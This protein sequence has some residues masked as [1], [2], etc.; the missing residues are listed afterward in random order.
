M[1][2]QQKCGV[3]SEFLKKDRFDLVL[4]NPPRTGLDNQLIDELLAARP[5]H[6][7][8][9]SCMPPTLA[10]D[11]RRFLE[12]GYRI[13]QVQGFEMFPQTTHVETVV[14]LVQRSSPHR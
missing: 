3:P 10:R 1:R 4:L 5:Q 9:V 7:I 13:E 6:L 11:L 2:N 8:Y 14:K 12:K